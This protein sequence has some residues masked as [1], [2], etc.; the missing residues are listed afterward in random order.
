MRQRDTPFS[1]RRVFE[2]AAENYPAIQWFTSHQVGIW[3]YGFNGIV[4][5]DYSQIKA[6]MQLEKVEEPADLFARLRL[7]ERGFIT[8]INRKPPNEQDNIQ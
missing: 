3:R 5:M 4:S 8:E 6:A 7:I 1:N 2:I